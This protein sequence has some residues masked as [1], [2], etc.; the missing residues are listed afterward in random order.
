MGQSHSSRQSEQSFWIKKSGAKCHLDKTAYYLFLAWGLMWSERV[1][2]MHNP[3]NKQLAK[4]ETESERAQ[5]A[6][7][8]SFAFLQ[9]TI[10]SY[11][12]YTI[13]LVWKK[14]RMKTCMFVLTLY[15]F[16]IQGKS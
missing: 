1:Q 3:T 10:A 6:C 4:V 14:K 11:N 8:E 7:L 13:Y 5:S 16:S 9:L 12:V 2:E 15:R